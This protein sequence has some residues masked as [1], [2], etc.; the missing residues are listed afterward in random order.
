MQIEKFNSEIDIDIVHQK[1][2]NG[3]RILIQNLAKGSENRELYLNTVHIINELAPKKY[4]FPLLVEPST[5]EQFLTNLISEDDLKVIATC[6]VISII[7][8]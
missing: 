1:K 5:F 8:G 2:G 3:F 6:K 7:L 4:I